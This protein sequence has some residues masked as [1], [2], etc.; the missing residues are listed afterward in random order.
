MTELFPFLRERKFEGI[1][2][3]SA[4]SP[5]ALTVVRTVDGVAVSALPGGSTAK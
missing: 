2:A 5:V 1:V 4:T 3:V